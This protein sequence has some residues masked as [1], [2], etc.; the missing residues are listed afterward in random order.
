MKG[1]EINFKGKKHVIALNPKAGP[2]AFTIHY[3]KNKYEIELSHLDR[4]DICSTWILEKIEAGEQIDIE[5]KD[6]DYTTEP[7]GRRKAFSGTNIPFEYS[8]AEI[9][10]QNKERLKYFYS[11]QKF[12]R[13]KGLIE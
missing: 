1:L 4:N 5:V 3:S 7:I 10:E 9:D 11:L 2:I 6:L 8:N 13:E 12:L